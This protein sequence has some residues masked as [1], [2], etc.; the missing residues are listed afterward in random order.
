[1]TGLLALVLLGFV[2]VLSASSD[3]AE[4][5]PA[6]PIDQAGLQG[7]EDLLIGGQGNDTLSGNFGEADVL[8]GRGGDDLLILQDGNVA[9]GGAGNDVFDVTDGAKAV[10]TDF[11]PA[12]DALQ[13]L[14]F[15]S[16]Q[17]AEQ[18]EH[19]S[20]E[21]T[22]NGVELHALRSAGAEPSEQTRLVTLLGLT[23]PPD[24]AALVLVEGR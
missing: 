10:I 16:E 5:D 21:V 9:T 15:E 12:E 3:E 18:P 11:D 8:D 22:R 20:W 2:G 13:V 7:Q 24:D 23:A 1:M 6:E 4:P 17:G 19:L 14:F